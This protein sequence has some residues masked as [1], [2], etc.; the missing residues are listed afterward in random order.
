[1]SELVDLSGQR[2]GRW[3]A[4]S[5]SDQKDKRGC[6]LWYL[7]RCS[8]GTEKL[9]LASNL[10]ER[11]TQSCGCLRAELTKARGHGLTN[12]R[13]YSTWTNMLNRCRNPGMHNYQYYGGRG[14]VVCDR[15]RNFESFLED[16]GK[17]PP[18]YEIDRVDNNGN[19][20]PGNCQWATRVTNMRNT[21]TNRLVEW[22]GECLSVSE[23]AERTGIPY[24]TLISRLRRGWSA[25][26]ALSTTPAQ[27]AGRQT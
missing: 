27:K 25:E 23:W 24:G 14:I 2:F 12:T 1:M 11:R 15:W 17:C 26:R 4:L 10:R 3:V 5:L 7:C 18:G 22:K 6:R 21:R 19:Y 16:M 8:C 20:E 13:E 9:V